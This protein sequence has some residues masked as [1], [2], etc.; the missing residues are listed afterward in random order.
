M[1]KDPPA[2]VQPSDGSSPGQHLDHNLM[3]D[4]EPEPSSEAAPEFL[5]RGNGDI[6]NV[7]CF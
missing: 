4:P 2:P 1:E 6:I 3:K 7:W 5:T